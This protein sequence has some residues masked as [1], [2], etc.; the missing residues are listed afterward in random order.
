MKQHREYRELCAGRSGS[1]PDM[2][3][4]KR[5]LAEKESKK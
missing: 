4:H 5:K 3:A 2:F 1:L